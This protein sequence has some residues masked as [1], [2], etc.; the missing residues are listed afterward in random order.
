M[1]PRYRS[2][3]LQ[4]CAVKPRSRTRMKIKERWLNHVTRRETIIVGRRVHPV[5]R[6]VEN[7]KWYV[8]R[9]LCAPSLVQ[10]RFTYRVSRVT[11]LDYVAG[12]CRFSGINVY[13]RGYGKTHRR[14]DREYLRPGTLVYHR[15]VFGELFETECSRIDE[16]TELT[17]SRSFRLQSARI[18][19][20][21]PDAAV[22]VES[23]V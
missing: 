14:C 2:R 9:D 10:R 22:R 1:Y 17:N 8:S 15:K 23:V 20:I 19:F 6:I 4:S 3:R 13:P 7:T 11:A 18:V 16:L 5:M 21:M 12:K